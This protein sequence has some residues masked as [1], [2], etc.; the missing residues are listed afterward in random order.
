MDLKSLFNNPKQRMMFLVVLLVLVGLIGGYYVIT[1]YILPPSEEIVVTTPKRLRT[2]QET[3]TLA[4]VLETLTQQTAVV[5]TYSTVELGRSNPFI[6]VIDLTP[7]KPV[8]SQPSS[9]TSSNVNIMVTPKVSS[10]PVK[11]WYS[12]FKLTGIVRGR[13][14]SYA[15]IEEGDRGY[16]LREGD[17][18]KSDIYV[19]K[20]NDNSVI[21]KRGNA[22]TTLK[23]GG[24]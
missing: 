23:L 14:R 21:L 18:L 24:E 5:F 12:G 4:Q 8:L 7:K 6:P 11:T 19:S 22:Y 9:V 10:E 15:I 16:V 17:F 3:Y 1:N 20:I 13:D 2:T